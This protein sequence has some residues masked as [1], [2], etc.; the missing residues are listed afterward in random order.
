[1]AAQGQS[2]FN[3]SGDTGAFTNAVVFPCASPNITQVGGTSLVTDTN[4]DYLSESVWNQ[5]GGLASGGGIAL[6]VEIPVWQMG[7]D[8]TAH[9]GSTLWRNVPDVA[10]T[11][12][13][14]YVFVDG[15][16]RSA[17]GTSCAAPL[18]AAFTALVNQQAAQL[19]Q[20]T[21]GFLN[22]ALYALCRGTN[23]RAIFHDITSGNN[24]N[25][26]S[27]T[28]FNATPGFDLCT[29]WGTPAGTNLINAL[30]T[31][32]PLGILPQTFYRRAVWLAARFRKPTGCSP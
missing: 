21:V 26:Y 11:A 19:G 20:P 6:S 22:P 27:P 4:G 17:A 2:F 24:T 9:G 29:G 14:V 1:M 15:R 10:L 23:Y 25:P 7:L 3:A 28:N 32:D 12:E 31:P 5:G 13:D 8:L 30:T 18:W 16:R